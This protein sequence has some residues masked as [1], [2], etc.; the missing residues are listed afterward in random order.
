MR[1]DRAVAGC[2]PQHRAEAA[3]VVQP[4]HRLV[5]DPFDVV[6]LAQE[7]AWRDAAQRARHAQ[8]HDLGAMLE[9]Q[10]QV[11]AAARAFQHLAS[12]QQA[13]Q[14]GRN[15]PAH[16]GFMDDQPGELAAGDDGVYSPTR[17]FDFGQFRHEPV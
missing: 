12:G 16:A 13:G 7:F 2:V 4:Q 6:V 3:R 8:M 5:E 10:Q 11:L 9:A 15:G 1:L 17:G 14:I